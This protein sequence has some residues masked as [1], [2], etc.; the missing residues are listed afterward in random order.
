MIVL[1]GGAGFIGS[2]ILGYLNKQ[3]IENIIVCDRISNHIQMKYLSD[4]KFY[5]FVDINEEVTDKIDFVIHFGANS[6]TLETEWNSVYRSNVL[7][8][9]NWNQRAL[10]DQIPMIFASSAAVVGNGE[11]PENL[12]AFSKMASEKELSNTAIFR[13]F[14]VYGPNEYHKGRMASTIYHWFNQVTSE[15]KLKIFRNSHEYHRDFIW[16]EDVA[17]VVFKTLTGFKPGFYD[18]GTNRS[19]SFEKVADVLLEKVKG[20]KEYIDMPE[21][22]QKQY[23]RHTRAKPVKIR[24]LGIDPDQFKNIEQGLDLY[25][26]YLVSNKIY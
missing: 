18:L 14:N 16:V 25:L 1:T 21:D 9:R 13:L 7:S 4:K 15:G 17:D 3:G 22:L 2:V 23:Q 11:G 5:K 12:Y 24:R 20:E 8:T 19:V 26:E 6:S 10:R